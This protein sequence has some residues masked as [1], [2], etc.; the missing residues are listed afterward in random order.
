VA[1]LQTGQAIRNDCAHDWFRVIR[2]ADEVS[3]ELYFCKR[4]GKTIR[5]SLK[6]TLE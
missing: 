6:L 2:P 1:N 3:S 5:I 4:C